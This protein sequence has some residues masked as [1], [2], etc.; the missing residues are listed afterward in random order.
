MS[1]DVFSQLNELHEEMNVTE[2]W[3]HEC[4]DKFA[5]Y[6][7]IMTRMLKSPITFTTMS[8][9]ELDEEYRLY[10]NNLNNSDI[11]ARE[12][13]LRRFIDYCKWVNKS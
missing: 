6:N 12:R 9:E 4:W 3:L 10:A 11:K 1:K 5:A 7:W 8:D 13:V 2:E